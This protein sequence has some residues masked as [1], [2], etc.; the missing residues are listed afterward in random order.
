MAQPIEPREYERARKPYFIK[1]EKTG[2][3]VVRAWFHSQEEMIG[4]LTQIWEKDPT[5]P[6]L[7]QEYLQTLVIE[8]DHPLPALTETEK[9]VVKMQEEIQEDDVREKLEELELH[10][11]ELAVRGMKKK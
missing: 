3:V 1:D 7:F 8:R 9:V 6:E 10:F 4:L 11:R 5:A 2:N